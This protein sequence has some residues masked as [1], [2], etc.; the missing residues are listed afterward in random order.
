MQ[1]IPLRVTDEGWTVVDEDNGR[2]V[3]CATSWKDLPA[4]EEKLVGIMLG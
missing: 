4:F 3:H 1:D 2:I